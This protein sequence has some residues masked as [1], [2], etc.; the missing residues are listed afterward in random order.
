MKDDRFPLEGKECHSASEAW[1]TVAEVAEL[2]GVTPRTVQRWV[3]SGKMPARTVAQ[4]RVRGKY[5][6]S[7]KPD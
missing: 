1:L 6:K 5:I 2:M 7:K 3:Q 4:E